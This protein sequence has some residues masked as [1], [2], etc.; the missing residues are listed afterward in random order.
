M[1]AEFG[2]KWLLRFISVTTLPAF[3]AASPDQ[4]TGF[5]WA[6]FVDFA[7][8]LAQAML[9]LYL[10]LRLP[11]RSDHGRV[12]QSARNGHRPRPFS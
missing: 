8:S 1:T 10:L 9:L 11:P 6:V 12:R 7:E 5:F 3:T 2:V 4:R